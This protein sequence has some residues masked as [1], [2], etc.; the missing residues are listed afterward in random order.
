MFTASLWLP[1]LAYA[2]PKIEYEIK[3]VPIRGEMAII[4]G[5]SLMPIPA[6][7]ETEMLATVTYYNN[8]PSQTDSTP[9][10]TASGKIVEEG[11]VANNCL[12]FGTVVEID[13]ETYTVHDRMNKKYDCFYF[14]I[15]SFSLE[16]AITFG[17]KKMIITIY[18]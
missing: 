7:T 16:E 4:G 10:L 11:I 12:E 9:D 8:L 15:F 1:A 14:D 17:K 18:N 3:P 5:N 6:I 13:G 2:P